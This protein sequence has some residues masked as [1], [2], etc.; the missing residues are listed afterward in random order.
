MMRKG[1]GLERVLVGRSETS[2]LS[3]EK[4]A[5]NKEPK[6]L[7]LFSWRVGIRIINTNK[8]RKIRFTEVVKNIVSY[9]PEGFSS[10]RNNTVGRFSYNVGKYN[11]S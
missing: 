6:R 7:T 10:K 8:R 5:E 11:D 3:T 2:E 9:G 1:I 4:L